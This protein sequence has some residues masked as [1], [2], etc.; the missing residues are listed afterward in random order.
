MIKIYVHVWINYAKHGQDLSIQV[1]WVWNDKRPLI[2]NQNISFTI[3]FKP[4]KI[5]C[6][7]NLTMI[8]LHTRGK[9]KLQNINRAPSEIS[10]YNKS[11]ITKANKNY[12]TSRPKHFTHNIS[13]K[14]NIYEDFLRK[15]YVTCH[16]LLC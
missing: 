8:T 1:V 16:Y 15:G 10:G 4:K 2:S 13:R 9:W 6:Q 14:D 3:L 11:P 12:K 5:L 7:K